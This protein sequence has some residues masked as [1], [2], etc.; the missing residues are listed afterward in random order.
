M[1][2]EDLGRKDN[3]ILASSEV[4]HCLEV[5]QDL[6]NQLLISS[7]LLADQSLLAVRVL[8]QRLAQ[9]TTEMFL[10]E[11]KLSRDVMDALTCLLEAVEQVA[12]ARH[13]IDRVR[14]RVQVRD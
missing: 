2:C 10:P 5:F 1:F 7:F 4:I 13:A 9:K 6:I 3:I 14:V 8:R 11:L 12:V